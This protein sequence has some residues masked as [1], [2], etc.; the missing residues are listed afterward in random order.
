MNIPHVCQAL[1]RC[2]NQILEPFGFEVRRIKELPDVKAEGFPAYVKKATNAGM[3]VNDWIEQNLGWEDVLLILQRTVFPYLGEN[4]TVCELGVGTGR[5]AR[6]IVARLTKGELYLVDHSP[7]IVDF[8]RGYFHS[9][10]RVHVL[11]ND[12]HSLPLER[13]QVDLIF[14]QGTFIELKLGLFYL[15]SLEFYRVLKPGGYCVLDYI[16]ITTEGGW[17]YL[18]AQSRQYGDCFTYHMPETVDRV[19][20]SAGFEIVKRHHMGKSTYLTV[21]KP[22]TGSAGPAGQ[23]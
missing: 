6:H 8:V 12:G 11:L 14:S 10:P 7:W 15:Y 22:D 19:F 9:N 21:R 16:D 17:E 2:M 4:S 5:S 20:S 3:D 13:S 18:R 23:P 1:K